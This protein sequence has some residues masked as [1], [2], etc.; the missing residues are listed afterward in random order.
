MRVTGSTVHSASDENYL[1]S[2]IMF[3]NI[4][5]HESFTQQTDTFLFVT[6]K[7]QTLKY[8]QNDIW[9]VA[10]NLRT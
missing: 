6:N 1:T 8:I 5:E 10:T 2:K 7:N 9:N 4:Y 3:I